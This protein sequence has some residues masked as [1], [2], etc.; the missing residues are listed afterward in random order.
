MLDMD[1]SLQMIGVVLSQVQVGLEH[2]ISNSYRILNKQ[3]YSY[4]VTDCELLA[5]RFFMFY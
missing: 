3:E 5:V 4:C 1:A 2:S